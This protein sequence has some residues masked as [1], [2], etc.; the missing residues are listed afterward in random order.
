MLEQFITRQVTGDGGSG[1]VVVGSTELFGHTNFV[2]VLK[3]GCDNSYFSL[4]CLFNEQIL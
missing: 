4:P 3:L 1:V 2:F